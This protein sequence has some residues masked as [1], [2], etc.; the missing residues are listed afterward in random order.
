MAVAKLV[1]CGAVR[2]MG[3]DEGRL[4]YFVRVRG[5]VCGN[6]WLT[7]LSSSEGEHD[8]DSDDTPEGGNDEDGHVPL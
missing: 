2:R 1:S 6:C 3:S 8:V 4:E 5:H 7:H